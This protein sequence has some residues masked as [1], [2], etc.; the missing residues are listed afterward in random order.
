M[1]CLMLWIMLLVAITVGV[2]RRSNCDAIV[3]RQVHSVR[4]HGR[5]RGC[6]GDSADVEWQPVC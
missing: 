5:R 6:R 3:S 1:I 4:Q 2:V